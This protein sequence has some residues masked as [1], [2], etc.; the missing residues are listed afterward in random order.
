[1]VAKRR[2]IT[3][4]MLETAK[5]RGW[6]MAQTAR[7]FE[8]NNKSIAAACERFGIALPYAKNSPMNWSSRR[9]IEEPEQPSTAKTVRFSA[10]PAAVRRALEKAR[11]EQKRVALEVR[12]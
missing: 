3:L 7:F 10:S 12:G 8:F 5:S 2:M 6:T 1:M 4:D 11:D 9:K